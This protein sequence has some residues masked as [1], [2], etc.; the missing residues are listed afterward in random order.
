MEHAADGAS[1]QTKNTKHDKGQTEYEFFNEKLDRCAEALVDL[2]PRHKAQLDAFVNQ[3]GPLHARMNTDETNT[4]A[5]VDVDSSSMSHSSASESGSDD[6]GLDG[7][8]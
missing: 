2:T 6:E 4:V 7:L 1:P 3:F 5:L 8:S